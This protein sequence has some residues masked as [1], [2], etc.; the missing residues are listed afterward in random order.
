LV[1]QQIIGENIVRHVVKNIVGAVDELDLILVVPVDGQ[2]IGC[3]QLWKQHRR[4]RPF[5][6]RKHPRKHP[7]LGEGGVF[8]E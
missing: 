1:L 4:R 3:T 5:H 6:R 7:Q 8:V 2:I